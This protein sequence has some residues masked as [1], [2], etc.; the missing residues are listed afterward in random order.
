MFKKKTAFKTAAFLLSAAMIVS[1]AAV[2]AEESGSE[3]SAPADETFQDADSE[4]EQ[5]AME[6]QKTG[7]ADGDWKVWS[8]EITP[9]LSDEEKAIFAEAHEGAGFYVESY[10]PAVL[11]A[12]QV[13][14][15]TNYAYLCR[16]TP[17]GDYEPAW[18]IAV[19]YQDTEGK[20]T[21]T[22]VR[23]LDLNA[24]NIKESQDAAGLVGAFE[25]A[26]GENTGE[27]TAA[28]SS[29]I[30]GDAGKA[31][32]KA[33]KGSTTLTPVVLLGTQETEDGTEQYFLYLCK[34][35]ILASDEK[36]T[37]CLL[38]VRSDAEN[39]AVTGIDELDLNSYVNDGPRTYI[40]GNGALSIELPDFSW[41]S[42]EDPDHLAAFSDKANRVEL[43]HVAVGES[44]PAA[45]IA[46]DSNAAVFQNYYSTPA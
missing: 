24:L 3:A 5:Q 13:V 20:N 14:S 12:T 44:Y 17:A 25:A 37:L 33:L 8:G 15:G 16:L 35:K 36:E 39:A 30:T 2:F 42:V 21:M 28:A 45:Q 34:G 43:S 32:E 23:D 41:R 9:V 1:P 11:L 31:L 22:S 7:R 19:V 26:D 4:A 18:R 38:E 27:S 40:T 6:A 29:V 10:D 46:S